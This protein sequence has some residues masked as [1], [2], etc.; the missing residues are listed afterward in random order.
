VFSRT[1]AAAKTDVPIAIAGVLISGVIGTPLGVLL[2]TRNRVTE[3]LL[4]FLDLF[5]ALPLLI[6]TIVIVAISGNG[7]SAAAIIVA[8][9]L[10]NTPLFIRLVRSESLVVRAR[11]FVEAAEGYGASPWRVSFR[12]VMPNVAGVALAQLSISSG[13][14]IIVIAALGFLGVGVHPPTPTWGSM[15]NE[16]SQYVADGK[17][18]LLAFPA[19]A[20]CV[21]V[22]CLNLIAEGVRGVL[23]HRSSVGDVRRRR[24]SL[25]GRTLA[26]TGA[27]IGQAR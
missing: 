22:V 5:Q 3:A 15:I 13:F 17:W 24:L 10:A 25:R 6:V 4:R 18:W 23:M 12:H 2:S 7:G 21:C 20:I 9:A 16:G 27:T 26:P 11:R 1:I 8:I 14:A 19:L